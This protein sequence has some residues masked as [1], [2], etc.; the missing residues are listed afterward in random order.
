MNE[1]GMGGDAGSPSTCAVIDAVD[2]VDDGLPCASSTGCDADA[3]GR[4]WSPPI[5]IDD[6]TGC[7]S[8]PLRVA[9]P[10][11]DRGFVAWSDA[12]PSRVR[13]RRTGANAAWDA[14]EPLG[15]AWGADLDA[16]VGGGAFLL[17]G[18]L[19]R[20]VAARATALNGSF[21][22]ASAL[23]SAL[24]RLDPRTELAVDSTGLALAIWSE[25]AV[26]HRY[27]TWT[28][29]A[30]WAPAA[31]MPMEFIRGSLAPMPGGGFALA[32]INSGSVFLRLYWPGTGWEAYGDVVNG[33]DEATAANEAQV[34]VAVDALE[35]IHVAY[36]FP[37][38]NDDY[39]E[40][41][42]DE[43]NPDETWETTR[44][45]V[46]GT[47]VDARFKPL[48]AVS[49]DGDVIL[50]WQRANSTLPKMGVTVRE[51]RSWAEPR[52]LDSSYVTVAPSVAMDATGNAVIAWGRDDT[53]F[54][55]VRA[56]SYIAGSGWDQST[57]LVLHDDSTATSVPYL[58]AAMSPTGQALIA[59][60]VRKAG[61]TDSVFAQTLR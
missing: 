17:L 3:L 8:G 11:V 6:G 49:D 46:G 56:N 59:Y 16:A 44:G 14:I 43:R 26:T 27:S 22:A 28:S 5:R 32:A 34:S 19:D 29:A 61:V 37:I 20:T 53:S 42:Y 12:D 33:F 7:V 23:S 35:H 10:N 9:L 55:L 54:G 47:G 60:V 52:S 39:A 31:A 51:N 18:S 41:L 45:F 58:S 25:G 57:Y 48:L 1:G 15:N 21:S 30:G 36:T 50:A 2:H 38:E 13:V 40:I 4:S 24:S